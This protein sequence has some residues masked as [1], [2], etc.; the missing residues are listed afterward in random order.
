[1]QILLS[2]FCRMSAGIMLLRNIRNKLSLIGSIY[3]EIKNIQTTISLLQESIGRLEL[4]QLESLNSDEL[5]RNEFRVFS[6]WGEDGILQFLIR[7]LCI[8]NKIF[9]EFGVQDYKEANTRFLLVNDNWSGLLIEGQAKYV[10]AIRQDSIYW[11][12]NLKV[13]NSFITKENINEIL[14]KN[15]V[16]GDIGLLSV[17]VD[18]NDYWIWKEVNC[19]SPAI[20]VCE[21]N[22]RFGSEKS[23]TV[24]YVPNFVRSTA[25]HS[26]IYYGAS[27]KAM[28]SLA[29]E[30]GYAFVGCNQAG[31]N[32]F[33]IRKDIKPCSIAELTLQEGFVRGKYRE[34]RRIDGSLS[35]LSDEE[36]QKLLSD[37]PLV[38][39]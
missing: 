31:N 9:V 25:H 24:P 32:A 26:M 35:C 2:G 20:V 17:D 34:S 30:K 12:H 16:K 27:L 11:K 21:Y 29:K 15:G 4:R 28:V 5:R 3:S 10:D 7:H 18:G 19:I 22:Y 39:V 13:E 33:F 14:L 1:M 6:Q 36:E 8:D 38:D 37:L 23:V